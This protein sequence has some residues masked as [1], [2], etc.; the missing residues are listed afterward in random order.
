MN[1]IAIVGVVSLAMLPMVGIASATDYPPSARAAVEVDPALAGVAE[2]KPEGYTPA[3]IPV[4]SFVFLPSLFLSSG[5]DT[6][7]TATNSNEKEDWLFIVHPAFQLQSNWTRH[8]L[9]FD[10]YFESGSYARYSDADFQNY[11]FGTN[12]RI[13]VS[14]DLE[15]FGYAR[16][17]HLN[18]LPGD[19]ETDTGLTAPLPYDQFTAGAAVR[20]EFNNLWTRVSFDFRDRDFD[21]FIDNVP[22]DQDYR[23]GQDYTVAGRVGYKISPLTSVF[24]NGSYRWYEM[25]DTDYNASSYA[26][27]TGLQFEPSRLLRGEVFV[28]YSEWTSDN[29]FLDDAP[30][31][32]YGANLAWFVSPLATV[33]FT[34]NQETLTTNYAFDGI[35]GSSVLSSDFGVRLDYELRRNIVLSGWFGYQNQDYQD[36]PRDDHQFTYGAEMRYLINRYATAKLNY[37]YIDF[38]TN[39]NNINGAES[40]T[41]SI[42]TAGLTLSY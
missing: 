5:Y 30:S 40:Y 13:D 23:D 17:S 15:L 21:D 6:N 2:R 36:Y 1:K 35:D 41:R 7:I 4:G 33:T 16:Y 37:N 19:D 22:T 31:L 32:T 25:E 9:S 34:A 18:E 24:V 11:S 3:G 26:I 8:Y 20:K 28:G 10:S 39:F 12:G 14:A 29:G 27:T 38:D 42:I